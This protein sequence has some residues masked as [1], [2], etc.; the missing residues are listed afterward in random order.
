M[1]PRVKACISTV[2]YSTD[3]WP[4]A[5]TAHA[6]RIP[7]NPVPHLGLILYVLSPGP[8][9]CQHVDNAEA[10]HCANHHGVVLKGSEE[11]GSLVDIDDIGHY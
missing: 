2:G 8:D 11:L 6:P 10:A 1:T 5:S 7:R 9:H 3:L 4:P